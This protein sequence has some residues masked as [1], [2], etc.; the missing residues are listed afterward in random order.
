MPLF[1]FVVDTTRSVL[2][3]IMFGTLISNWILEFQM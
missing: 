1:K 2:N 3:M